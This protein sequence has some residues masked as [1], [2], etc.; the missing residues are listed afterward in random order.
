MERY[1]RRGDERRINGGGWRKGKN[2]KKKKGI[3]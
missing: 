1:I 2:I 3:R